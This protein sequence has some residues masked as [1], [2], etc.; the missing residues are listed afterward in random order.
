[1][2]LSNRRLF[3]VVPINSRQQIKV[4]QTDANAPPLNPRDII[5]EI[6][7]PSKKIIPV[8]IT[9]T[10]DGRAVIAEFIPTEVGETQL[11]VRI[12]GSPVPQ[13]PVKFGVSP[14]PDPTKVVVTGPGLTSG[15]VGVPTTFRIDARK[16]GVA[17]LGVNIDGPG[18]FSFFAN[19]EFV[20]N[21]G[22]CS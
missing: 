16:A 14:L 5:S 15:E 2:L 12:A 13:T 4:V 1:M 22:S 17:P 19:T 18:N 21:C 20:Y 10:P 3:T 9:P 6:T 7:T 8:K 11:A